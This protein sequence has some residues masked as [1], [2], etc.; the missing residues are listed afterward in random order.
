LY[1][2]SS[3]MG[4]GIRHLIKSLVFHFLFILLAL[5]FFDYV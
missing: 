2:V 3:P 5:H 4:S 1:I